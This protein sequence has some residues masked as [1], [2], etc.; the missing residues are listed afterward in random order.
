MNKDSNTNHKEIENLEKV[1]LVTI[2]KIEEINLE[3]NYSKNL[4]AIEV[5]LDEVY[6]YVKKNNRYIHQT[7]SFN[8]I[9]KHLNVLNMN[10]KKYNSESKSDYISN[11]QKQTSLLINALRVYM[12]SNY[13]FNEEFIVSKYK[14]ILKL[15]QNMFS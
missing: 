11:I 2:N 15:I 13:H 7:S 9:I 12:G 10:I 14:T 8:D 1:I 3:K 5:N 6:S 4:T